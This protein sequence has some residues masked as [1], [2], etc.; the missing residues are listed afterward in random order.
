MLDGIVRTNLVGEAGPELGQLVLCGP[1]RHAVLCWTGA[2]YHA[3][4]TAGPVKVRSYAGPAAPGLQQ[5][6]LVGCAVQWWSSQQTTP[7]AYTLSV[8]TSSTFNIPAARS[9][10]RQNLLTATSI[11]DNRPQQTF[12]LGYVQSGAIN[13]PSF[14]LYVPQ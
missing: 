1:A 11:A 10:R 8:T 9:H 7:T 6:M 5:V 4:C 3:R 14:Q 13:L 12:L 2:V